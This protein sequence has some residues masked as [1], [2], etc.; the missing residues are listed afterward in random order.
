MSNWYYRIM[1][2]EIGPLSTN[3]LIQ[4]VH[5]KK[6][7]FDT[8]VRR[9][10]SSEW[11]QAESVKGLFESVRLWQEREKELAMQQQKERKEQALREEKEREEKRQ[12]DELNAERDRK[13]FA[14]LT[15][16]TC[17]PPPNYIFEILDTVFAFDSDGDAGVVLA[18]NGD[19]NVA[20]K[21]VKHRLKQA[22]FDI[23]ADAVINCQF[24]YR[25][26]VAVNRTSQ[27][28]GAAISGLMDTN[29]AV[30]PSCAQAIEIFAYGT[31]I[32]FLDH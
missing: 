20:F 17:S 25:V 1:G 31:A 21:R 30:G 11:I 6:V 23:G 7:D 2:T 4:A 28:I 3:Q 10:D 16:S 9:Y 8:E 29:I 22:A 24:E 19:P 5:E 15:V 27:A 18:K 13:R 12:Q 32:R 26:A 14:S